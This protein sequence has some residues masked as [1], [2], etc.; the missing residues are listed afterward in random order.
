M[1]KSITT[2]EAMIFAGAAATALFAAYFIGELAFIGGRLRGYR[3]SENR[4]AE[5][6]AKGFADM[7]ATPSAAAASLASGN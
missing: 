5:A 4:F 2:K 3:D 7:P 6:A 1:L